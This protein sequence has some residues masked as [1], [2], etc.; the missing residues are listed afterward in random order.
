MQENIFLCF[1]LHQ[2]AV[3]LTCC[4]SVCPGDVTAG[5]NKNSQPIKRH[6]F[7]NSPPPSDWSLIGSCIKPRPHAPL[8][9]ET[10]QTKKEPLLVVS[11]KRRI[12][13]RETDLNTLIWNASRA[14]VCVCSDLLIKASHTRLPPLLQSALK[15]RAESSTGRFRHFFFFFF[16]SFLMETCGHDLFKWQTSPFSRSLSW[17]I[18][19]WLLMSDYFT[20]HSALDK[21]LRQA[22]KNR[23]KPL[24]WKKGS[25]AGGRRGG[26]GAERPLNHFPPTPNRAQ[27]MPPIIPLPRLIK[28]PRVIRERRRCRF[29]LFFPA[30]L[31]SHYQR[32]TPAYPLKYGALQRARYITGAGR[33]AANCVISP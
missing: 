15:T 5:V 3:S 22:V 25:G 16:F 33:R 31:T 21:W 26:W 28:A 9:Q 4:K 23:S 32:G 24:G 30:T 18:S 10:H 17:G 29:A 13:G 14:C 12:K 11:L 2:F 20:S 27:K 8:Q 19:H 6:W 1:Y 7:S